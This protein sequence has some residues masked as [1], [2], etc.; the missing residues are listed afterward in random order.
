[1]LVRELLD[2]AKA[3]NAGLHATIAG[4]RE[5]LGE[6][7]AE[8]TH[9]LKDAEQETMRSVLAKDKAEVEFGTCEVRHSESPFSFGNI[10]LASV[11]W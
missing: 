7:R 2:A 9:A 1:M 5:Q 3:T 11:D 10:C 4:L 6:E 8:W